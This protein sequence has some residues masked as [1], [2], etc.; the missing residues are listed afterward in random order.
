M[1]LYYDQ[2]TGS[3]YFMKYENSHQKEDFITQFLQYMKAFLQGTF[4]RSLRHNCFMYIP[5]YPKNMALRQKNTVKYVVCYH[6]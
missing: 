4:L 6:Q 3:D 2:G 5:I 1:K